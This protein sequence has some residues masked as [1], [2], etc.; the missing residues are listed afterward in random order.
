[1]LLLAL[2]GPVADGIIAVK[3]KRG[4]QPLFS[5]SSPGY[6][7][8][9]ASAWGRSPYWAALLITQVLSWAFFGLACALV[10][11]TWQERKTR[12]A[13]GRGWSYAWKYGGLKRRARLRRT[14]LEPQPI[15]WLACRERWQMLGLWTMALLMAGGFVVVLSS[16]LPMGVWITWNYIGGLFTLILYLWAA[17]QACRFLVE[18]R[19]SGFLELLL[20]APVTEKQIIGGQWLG[21]LRMFGLPVLLLVSAGVAGSVLSQRSFQRIATQ[22]SSV[23]VA[24]MTNQNGTATNQRVVST[25]VVTVSP[26]AGTNAVASQTTPP[27]SAR[28]EFFMTLVTAAAAA[29]STMG[30]LLALGWFGMWMGLI[31]RTANLATLKTILF[32]QVIPWFVIAFCSTMAMA[33]FMAKSV[34]SGSSAQPT[35]WLVWWPLVTAVVSTTLALLKD[36]GFIVW[37]RKKLYSSFR[38]RAAK[39]VSQTGFVAL[40]PLPV[41]IPAPPV[42]AAQP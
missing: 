30:N 17:S 26:N 3:I 1:M 11:H 31:S 16:R 37:S 27:M 29:L 8:I 22:V 25:T 12:L 35:W 33:L 40:P 28:Q 4:F 15:A 10:P 13:T 19:R 2:C 32:V 7:L 34:F 23:T 21:V 36:I 14:L 38:E 6:V 41:A 9:S 39:G 42:I 18:V 20:A 5:L 24:G